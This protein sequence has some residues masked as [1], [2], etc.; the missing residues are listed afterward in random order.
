MKALVSI[1]ARNRDLLRLSLPVFLEQT[2][3]TLLAYLG[4]L[5]ISGDGLLVNALIQATTFTNI[6][7][8]FSNLLGVGSIILLSRLEG[9]GDPRSKELYAISLYGNI[10]LGILASLVLV[11]GAPFFFAL[12]KVDPSVLPLAEDYMLIVGSTAVL[13]FVLT[14]FAA[15]LRAKELNKE[16]MIGTT[17]MLVSNLGLES[18][19]LFVFNSGIKGVAYAVTLAR[20]LGLAV[21]AYYYLKKIHVSL[22][23]KMLFP[24]DQ[25]LWGKIFKVGFNTAFESIS[26]NISFLVMI[27]FVNS[28][29]VREG[30]VLN[31]VTTLTTADYLFG[32]SIVQVSQVEEGKAL[33]EK[34]FA[35]A[36]QLVKDAA[37][38]SFVVSFGVSLLLW[39]IS[40]PLFLFLMR[41]DSDPSAAAWLAFEILGIDCLFEIGRILTVIYVR[42]LQVAGDGAFVTIMGLIF[43]WLCNVGLGYLLGTYCGLG[44]AGCWLGMCADTLIRGLAFVWRWRGRKWHRYRFAMEIKN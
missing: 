4:Q 19:A 29:G 35:K 2:V 14:S 6:V 9:A 33:G 40:Y 31:F 12:I 27:S 42:S 30:N 17:V 36:E 38:M 21:Y 41:S 10:A 37:W 15:Y 26:Y 44:L 25:D 8:L 43:S 22:A 32:N 34:N 23:P 39:G 1:F 3:T 16:L 13:P 18:L 24:W 28:Y 7:V 20:F 11:F 5:V